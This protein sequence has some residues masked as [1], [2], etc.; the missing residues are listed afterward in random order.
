M[1][2]ISW[3]LVLRLTTML[4]FD[5]RQPCGVRGLDARQHIGHREVHIVHAAEDGVVQAVQAHGHAV[6]G[7]R[8]RVTGPC[9]QQG[10][11]GGEREV[12]A[13]G[14]RAVRSWPAG[15]S[16]APSPLRSSG[17]PP[18]RRILRT[19][20]AGN[21]VARRVISSKLSSALC[22]RYGIVLVE[23]VLG[24]AVGRSGSCSGRSR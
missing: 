18:V 7:P 4:T 12:Q 2:R 5:V 10:A 14:L 19:P 1:G 20:C 9:G 3:S 6:R 16:A 21:S 11:V 13:R 8:L 23:D 24:H 15:Q 17:S 22:G